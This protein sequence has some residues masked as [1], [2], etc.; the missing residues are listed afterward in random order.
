MKPGVHTFVPFWSAG[1]CI[2]MRTLGIG[3]W[4][5]GIGYWVLGFG[6]CLEF[7]AWNM[8]F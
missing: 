5:L 4:V 2:F 1:G 3:Y 7:G 6:I 8:E